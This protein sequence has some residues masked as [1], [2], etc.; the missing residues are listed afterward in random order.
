MQTCAPQIK[1]LSLQLCK[2]NIHEV[3][4]ILV[5]DDLKALD[6]CQSHNQSVRTDT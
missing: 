3:N 2:S 6:R 4:Y 5:L 1:G